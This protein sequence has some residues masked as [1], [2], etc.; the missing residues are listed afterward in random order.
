MRN[1]AF[2]LRPMT[3]LAHPEDVAR[4]EEKLRLVRILFPLR[5]L[6]YPVLTS[7]ITSINYRSNSK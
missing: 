5:Q 3:Q 2:R 6:H 4:L 1:L 7:N